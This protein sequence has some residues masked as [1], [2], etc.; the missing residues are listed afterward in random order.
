MQTNAQY[1]GGI[2]MLGKCKINDDGV[3]EGYIEHESELTVR[4]PDNVTVIGARAFSD[5]TYI[6]R[7]VIPKTVHVIEEEAFLNCSSLREVVIPDN[8]ECI[9]EAAFCGCTNLKSIVL[10]K[11]VD[12]INDSTFMCCESLTEI[13]AENIKN[14]NGSAFDGCTNLRHIQFST[15]LESLDADGLSFLDCIN[16]ES[17]DVI[18]SDITDDGFCSIDGALYHRDGDELELVVFPPAKNSITL[19]DDLTAIRGEAFFD[20][21]IESIFIPRYVKELNECLNFCQNLENISVDPSNDSYSSFD[22][23]LYNKE[24]TE[25]LCCPKMKTAVSIF[26]STTTIAIN[27]FFG[28]TEINAINLKSVQEIEYKAFADCI[29]LEKIVFPEHLSYVAHSAFENTKWFE[30]RRQNDEVVTASNILI[31]ASMAVKGS[32]TVIVP[33]GITDISPYC[34]ENNNNIKKVILPNSIKHIGGMAFSD[35]THLED[36]DLCN[37]ETLGDALFYQCYSLKE[38]TLPKSV[39]EIDKYTFFTAKSLSEIYVDEN[40]EHFSSVN[41]MLFSKD[42]KTLLAIP[43]VIKD[44]TIPDGTILISKTAISSRIRRL[45]I[46]ESIDTDSLSELFVSLSTLIDLSDLIVHCFGSKVKSVCE[47]HDIIYEM[48]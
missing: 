3:L 15:D 14:V 47:K 7:V 22:G 42:K 48:I 44:V 31:D 5:C 6:K 35:C 43:E 34:F 32:G 36:I 26:P 18:G 12:T 29:S 11:K 21:Q 10:P 27:A 17:I 23:V 16:L 40:N 38:I 24:K 2:K 30:E 8:I 25:L 13:N 33:E 1:K 39:K 41:G 20:S 9:G 19:P 28:C 46:P 45:T 4:I 37:V